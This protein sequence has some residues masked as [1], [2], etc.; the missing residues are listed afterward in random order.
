MNAQ[1]KDSKK[2]E[3]R[4]Y[5]HLGDV[6]GNVCA[7][8]ACNCIFIKYVTLSPS[9]PHA[10]FYLFLNIFLSLS[11]PQWENYAEHFLG[12]NYF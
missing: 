9:P 2:P 4:I 5:I 1:K 10:S 8:V 3:L 11:H 12:L 7:N 6:S